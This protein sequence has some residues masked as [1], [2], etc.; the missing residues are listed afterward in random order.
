MEEARKRR[1]RLTEGR[2]S[3]FELKPWEDEVNWMGSAVEAET[4]LNQRIDAT[5]E[6]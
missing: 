6:S 5:G 4:I 2:M 3:N 1:E